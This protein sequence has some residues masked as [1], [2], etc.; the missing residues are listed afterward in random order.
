MKIAVACDHGG[1]N[2][3]VEVIKL[4]EHKGIEYEDLG[5]FSDEPVDY[6]DIALSLAEAVARGEYDRGIVICGTGIGVSIA[7]NKVKGI[8][9]ALCHDVY[10]ARMS[11]LHNDANVLAMG[12]RVIGPGLARTIVE[13]WL[14]TGFEGGRHKRRIDKISSYENR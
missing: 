8:R 4:L 2:L 6:P 10:S 13:E 3:K 7:A 12:A 11:R 5:T 9:A 1:L 14:E